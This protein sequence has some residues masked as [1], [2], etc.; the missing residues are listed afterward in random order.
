MSGAES[1]AEPR[2]SFAL[3]IPTHRR[4]D[5]VVQ[6]VDSALRQSRAFDQIIVVTDGTR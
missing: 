5:L 4:V 2:R 1:G 3:V 6:A